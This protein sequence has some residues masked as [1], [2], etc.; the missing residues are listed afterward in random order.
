MVTKQGAR[1]QIKEFLIKANY[2]EVVD[3]VL[4]G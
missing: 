3:F 2:V 4:M 1:E